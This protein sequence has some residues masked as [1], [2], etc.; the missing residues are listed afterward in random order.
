M[1]VRYIGEAR[2][3]MVGKEF[4]VLSM[5]VNPGGQMPV[6]FTL[7]RPEGIADWGWHDAPVLYVSQQTL[8]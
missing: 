2:Q 7:D 5:M 4:V 6:T 8:L 3:E 1:I